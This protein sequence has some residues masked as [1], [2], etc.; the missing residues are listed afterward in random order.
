VLFHIAAD[1][2]VVLH[3]VFIFFAVLGG[4][5]VLYNPRFAWL[6][7]PALAWGVWIEVSHGIC[8][9]TPIENALRSRAGDAG[10][11]GGFIDHYLVS[12][13]YP[14]GLSPRDQLY[15]AAALLATNLT[16][17]ATVLLRY[18]RHGGGPAY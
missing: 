17:Y 3:L 4:W 16:A 11:E 12:V 14:P 2:V 10:Y 13:I 9:L 18:R 1:A 8:P 5:L 7:L 15:L 6:H